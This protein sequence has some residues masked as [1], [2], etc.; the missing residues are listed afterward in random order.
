MRTPL[1]LLL[2]SLASFGASYLWAGPEITLP[3]A[4]SVLSSIAAT[5]L[6]LKAALRRTPVEA[7]AVVVA[8]P[9]QPKQTKQSKARKLRKSAPHAVIDGSNVMHWNG[10]TP[11]LETIREVVAN[12]RTQ[13]YQPG[14]I[15]DAN[16]GYKLCDRYLDDKDFAKLLKLP[17]DRVLV[18]NKGEQADSTILAAARDLNAKVV[19]NDRFRDWE[20]DFPEVAAPGHLVKG[21]YRAG[22]LWLDEAVLTA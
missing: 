21:G 9:K 8:A 5:L 11:R 1:I 3:L 15:F 12:V 18:V 10:E 6:I 14:I 4:L 22:Q 16:A 19:T 7:E 20:A 17:G 13:G 2:L